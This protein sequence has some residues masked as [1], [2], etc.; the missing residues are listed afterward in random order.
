MF[1]FATMWDLYEFKLLVLFVTAVIAVILGNYIYEMTQK[2]K[3]KDK[4]D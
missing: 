2:E 3:R 1:E 4:D